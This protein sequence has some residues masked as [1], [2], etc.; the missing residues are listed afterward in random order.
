MNLF[1]NYALSFMMSTNKNRK[2]YSKVSS[3]EQDIFYQL[4]VKIPFYN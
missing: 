1:K 4:E 2:I 3:Q